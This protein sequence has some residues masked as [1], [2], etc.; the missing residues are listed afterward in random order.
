MLYIAIDRN[1][2]DPLNQQVYSGIVEKILNGTLAAGDKMPS[3][4]NFSRSLGVSRNVV[5]EAYDQ[6]AAEG[7]TEA[8][9]GSGT[10]VAEG[11]QLDGY[12]VGHPAPKKP[13]TGLLYEPNAQM[14][15]FR[16]GVPDLSLFPIK[17]WGALYRN[18]CE[19]LNPHTLDY[20]QAQGCYDLRY[21]LSRYLY[22]SRGVVCDADHI[23][24]TTGAAQAFA[25][26]SRVLTP[27]EHVVVEDPIHKDILKIIRASG[28]V[29]HP[30]IVDE[31]GIR[32]D[33]LPDL[34]TVK[35]IFATPSHHFPTGGILSAQ[36]RI[37]L[38]RYAEQRGGY[39]VEDDYDSEYHFTGAPI[40]SLQSLNPDRVIYVGT[41]SKKLFPALRIGYMVL[42]PSLINAFMTAKHLEDLHSP[43]LEQITLAHFIQDGLLDRY[44]AKSRRVYQE[45]RRILTAA[46]SRYFGDGV[47]VKGS[48][49]GIH[50]VAEF[51]G[52][53]FDSEM[54]KRL[55]N[56]GVRF[57]PID[58][59]TL[60]KGLYNHSLM[61]GYGNLTSV[62]IEEGVRRIHTVITKSTP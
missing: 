48:A 50:L 59:H 2:K 31:Q 26:T 3:S 57:Y 60:T 40:H 27:E 10:Y 46:L 44:I 24:I 53:C 34:E 33:L 17:K 20:Y 43:V 18:V 55:K 51:S 13:L 19:T 49:T 4:R 29:V 6:L 58:D 38:I 7:F 42:P 41:F 9:H 1:R 54:F 25:L 5:L 62:Q 52:V 21:A 23:L 45:K 32:A 22:K 16:T 30:V 8:R 37:A 12:H 14:I 11:I 56:G 15:D 28:A 61:I 39:I 36:R 35:Y 47:S